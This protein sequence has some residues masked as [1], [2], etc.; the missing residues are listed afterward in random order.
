[1]AALSRIGTNLWVDVTEV[2]AVEGA[3]GNWVRLTLRNGVG[4]ISYTSK[5]SD[6]STPEK[7]MR[8]K[9]EQENLLMMGHD[10]QADA[11]GVQDT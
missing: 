9:Q 10:V 8:F 2:V 4:E 5:E 11:L 6:L 3:G 7:F 1:M